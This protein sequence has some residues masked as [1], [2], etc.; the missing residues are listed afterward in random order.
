MKGRIFITFTILIFLF[1][2]EKGETDNTIL[3]FYSK[4][5]K[6]TANSIAIAESS[7][8]ETFYY[9]CGQFTDSLSRDAAGMPGVYKAGVDGNLIGSAVTLGDYTGSASKVIVSGEGD[10]VCTG[11]VTGSNSEKDIFVWKLNQD[12]TTIKRKVYANADNQYGIDIIETSDGF[13]VLAATDSKREPEGE[14]TGNPKGKKDILL[15]KINSNLDPVSAIPAVG[16]NGNDEGVAVKK[17]LN[18]GFIVVGTTDISDRPSSEQSG[19]NIIIVRLNS[20]GN[21][22]E[23]RIVGG[24]E[25]EAASDFE[26]LND[27]YLIA[28]TTG[29]AGT[30]LQ[31]H[32]WKMQQNIY[33]TPEFNHPIDLEPLVTNKTPYSVK[34]ICRYKTNS[35]IV[36]GQFNTGLSARMLVFSVDS[37]GTPDMNRIKRT[38]G[39]GTQV[40]NDVV[41]DSSGNIIAVGNNSYENNSMICFLK[42]GF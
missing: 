17:E 38:G 32:I 29:I 12:L 25:N 39:T 36:A 11:Y 2:C 6:E 8:G 1:S 34:S 42:F 37:Y 21:T 31:G 18:G 13:L 19:T 3:K 26:V 40:A 28:G 15:L 9:I 4:S 35:Y 27:G 33:D 30:T 24:T 23:P 16:F 7:S 22:T 41:T 14:L 5:Y 10:I 20:E